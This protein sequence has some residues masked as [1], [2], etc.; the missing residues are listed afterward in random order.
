MKNIA[1]LFLLLFV[2][3]AIILTSCS[4]KSR[5]SRKFSTRNG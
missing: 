3:F 5:N 2:P 4:T 1:Y